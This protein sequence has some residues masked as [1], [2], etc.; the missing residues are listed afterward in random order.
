MH[1]RFS[2]I[3]PSLNQGEFIGRALESLESQTYTEVEIIIVD[4]G[5]ADSS[6]AQIQAFAEKSKRRVFWS[7]EPDSGQ[8]A[9]INKGLRRATGEYFGYL[10]SDDILYPQA[11][12][13]AAKS[14]QE[15]AKLKW[16][17]GDADLEY[18]NSESIKGYAVFGWDYSKLLDD[19]F[20]S[21]PACFWSRVLMDKVGVFDERLWGAFDYDF[22][23]RA[24]KVS[25]PLYLPLRLAATSCHDATKTFSQPFR[26]AVEKAEVQ[27]TH[28]GGLISLGVARQIAA[29]GAAERFSRWSS[30][31]G[32]KWLAFALLYW[33]S[34]L[35]EGR[36]TKQMRSLSFWRKW[37]YPPFDKYCGGGFSG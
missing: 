36:R 4:G 9:A 24:G 33:W 6:V 8:C 2:I 22:W 32:C 31:Y 19:C 23:L 11:L 13:M 17:Y 3:V 5:S 35:L 14:F 29:F 10:N 34:F 7:S 30:F 20:I 15:N 27:A 37:I 18:R 12:A 21:Q 1:P 26:L 25:E 16:M 28:N